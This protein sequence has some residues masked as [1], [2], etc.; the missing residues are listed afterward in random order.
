[1][2]EDEKNFL[3]TMST[4]IFELEMCVADYLQ[5]KFTR[6]EFFKILTGKFFEL[7]MNII[8]YHQEH[9]DQSGH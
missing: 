4:D 2:K 5:H 8:K 3:M 1:M 6:L 7:T 9:M